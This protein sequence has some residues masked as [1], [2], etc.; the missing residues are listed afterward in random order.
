V[1]PLYIIKKI[2]RKHLLALVQWDGHVAIKVTSFGIATFLLEGGWTSHSVFD[3]PIALGRDS[4]CS[5]LVQSASHE[6]LRE[7]KLI[8]WDETSTHHR[9]A[10]VVDWTLRNIMQRPNSPFG[11]KVVIFEGDF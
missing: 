8:V 1:I 4:M 7:A 3:I 6:L 9:R 10:E 11:G 2:N 5:I